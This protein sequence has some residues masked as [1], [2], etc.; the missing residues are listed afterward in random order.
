MIRQKC[1]ERPF[2]CPGQTEAQLLKGRE[3]PVC[4]GRAGTFPAAQARTELPQPPTG[5]SFHAG[6]FH[7]R[8]VI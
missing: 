4:I 2:D 1:P 5:P 3:V 7:L 6:W 8:A